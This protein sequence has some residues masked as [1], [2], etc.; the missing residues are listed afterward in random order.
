MLELGGLSRGDTWLHLRLRH[1]V[2]LLGLILEDLQLLLHIPKC[3]RTLEVV[4]DAVQE[5]AA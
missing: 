4:F 1:A 3:I 2:D 5:Q